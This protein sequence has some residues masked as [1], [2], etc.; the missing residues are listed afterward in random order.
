MKKLEV[1]VK[2]TCPFCIRIL[3]F[4]DSKDLDPIVYDVTAH[5]ELRSE[6]EERIPNARTVPQSLVDD[7]PIGGCDD[8]MSLEA[9][10]EFDALFA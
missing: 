3:D 6:M 4:Y 2:P 1:Y 10:G 8:V 7:V 5:P 9:K